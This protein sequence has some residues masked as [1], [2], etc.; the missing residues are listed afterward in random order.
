MRRLLMVLLMCMPALVLVTPPADAGSAK[1]P[2]YESSYDWMFDA[3]VTGRLNSLGS[4][5]YYNSYDGSCAGVRAVEYWVVAGTEALARDV[6]TRVDNLPD[7][8]NI[9]TTYGYPV[10]PT[11][12]GCY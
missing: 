5:T 6:C 11:F 9:A 8:E 10:P 4:V 2:C 3:R 12:W 1:S 7:A